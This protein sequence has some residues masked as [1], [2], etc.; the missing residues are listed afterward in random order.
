MPFKSV[1]QEQW[2]QINKPTMWK[3]WVAE[4]GHARGYKT[5]IHKKK[6]R[7]SK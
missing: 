6:K 7:K 4:S 1:K 2:M 5:A 3:K